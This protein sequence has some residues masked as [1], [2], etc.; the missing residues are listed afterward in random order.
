MKGVT[1]R[2]KGEGNVGESEK[3]VKRQERKEKIKM[4]TTVRSNPKQKKSQYRSRRI[5]CLWDDGVLRV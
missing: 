5:V 1:A 4:E 3:E 2:L